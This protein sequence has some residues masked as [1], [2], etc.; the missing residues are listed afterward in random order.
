MTSELRELE[1]QTIFAEWSVRVPGQRRSLERFQQIARAAGLLNDDGSPFPTA[2]VVGSKGKGTTA[3]YASASLN[4]SGLEVV[5]VTSPALRTNLERIRWNGRA[6]TESDYRRAI[7]EIDA[8]RVDTP[9]EDGGYLS[10]TGWFMLIGLWLAR[11][12]DANALVVEAGRGGRSD[13]SSCLNPHAIAVTPVFDEHIP[14]LGPTVRA[15][16]DEKIGVCGVRTKWVALSEELRSDAL[17]AITSFLRSRS[18]P[19]A[20]SGPV[21]LPNDLLSPGLS[22]AN[23]RLGLQ[24]ASSFRRLFGFSDPPYARLLRVMETVRNIGRLSTHEIGEQTLVLDCAID[25]DGVAAA[26]AWTHAKRGR[27]PSHVVLSLPD[28]KPANGMVSEVASL[29]HTFVRIET[30]HL[31]FER[32]REWNAMNINDLAWKELG[33]LLLCVGTVSF[34]GELT[35]RFDIPTDPVFQP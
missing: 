28:D 33:A 27:P 5:T 31:R 14:E 12:K 4:A 22:R 11:E 3:L 16:A 21:P 19:M 23:A 2:V 13:E 34:I 8:V 29:P 7:V 18:I 20:L 26:I 25:R 35:E 30:P 9:Q 24:L 15:V 6:I 10:P 1:N 17:D 32:L